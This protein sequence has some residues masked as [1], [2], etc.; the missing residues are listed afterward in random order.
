MVI[1]F[2]E[3]TNEGP[4][5]VTIFIYDTGTATHPGSIIVN[6]TK[7]ILNGTALITVPLVT[8]VS[9]AGHTE[10]WVAVEWT[11]KVDMTHYAFVDAGPAVVGKGDWIYLNNVWQ[12]IHSSID[13]NWAIG[14][15]VEGQGLA[16]I[17]I[18]N[19][20]GPVGVK[21]DVQNTGDVDA[22]NIAWSIEAK[23]GILGKLDKT[24]TGSD[25][26]LLAHQTLAI[27]LPMFFG[28]GKISILIKAHAANAQEVIT[29]KSAF[30]L[31]PLVIGI[32]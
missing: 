4:M 23:G 18:A 16:Q 2:G 8:P 20:K 19:V 5:N 26:T 25:T 30:V 9:L 15:I 28:F 10:L 14:A 12:E 27:S 22:T 21:A 11:Q 17:G 7:A 1:G 3:D 32:K 6:D 29:T 31:G 13:A 24:N